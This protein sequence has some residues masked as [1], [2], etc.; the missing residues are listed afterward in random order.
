[1][2]VYNKKSAIKAG[3]HLKHLSNISMLIIAYLGE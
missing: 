2:E 3:K 1:M